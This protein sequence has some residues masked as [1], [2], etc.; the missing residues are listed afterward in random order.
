[1]KLI[2][3]LSGSG[4]L[5]ADD[6]EFRGV[7]YD[8]QVWSAE[9]GLISAR[10]NVSVSPVVGPGELTLQNGKQITV[11]VTTSGVHGATIIIKGKVPGFDEDSHP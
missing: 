7:H 9:S 5:V 11:F 6:H 1:M 8:I 2:G 4:K 10:G 3:Q